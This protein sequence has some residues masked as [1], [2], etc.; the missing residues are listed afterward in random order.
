MESTLFLSQIWGPVF[1]AVGIGMFTSRNYYKKIYTDLEKDALA[2]L[3]FGMAA[4]A[5]GIAHIIFHNVW[6]NLSQVLISF[7]G[8]A[9]F[10]KGL[11]FIVAP[12]FVDKAGDYWA[13]KKIIPLA[14]T[15]TLIVGVYLTWIAYL[16]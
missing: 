2:V 3:V 14:G 6:G 7:F 15:I 5:A 10:V 16:A 9:L 12:N 13:K 11:L 4:M 8:W 1:L